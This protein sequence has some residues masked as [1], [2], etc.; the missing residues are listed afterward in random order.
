M[1]SPAAASSPS[2]VMPSWSAV[3]SPLHNTHLS[4]SLEFQFFL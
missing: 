2:N 1:I 4:I 3:P